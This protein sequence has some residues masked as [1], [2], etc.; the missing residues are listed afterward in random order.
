MAEGT[1]RQLTI[2]ARLR[3]ME[4][5]ARILRAQPPERSPQALAALDRYVRIR[6]ED[7]RAVSLAEDTPL[8]GFHR[9]R[10]G[11]N[12]ETIQRHFGT[13]T[14]VLK[15]GKERKPE[16]RIQ[17]W[18][19]RSALLNGGDLRTPLGLTGSLYD[20]L[21]F[22][23]DEVSLG[24]AKHGGAIRCDLL[25]VGR[26]GEASFPVLIEL[27]SGREKT[28]LLRQLDKFCREIVEHREFF[29]RLLEACTGLPIS[30][31]HARKLILWPKPDRE[32]VH[33]RAHLRELVDGGIDVVEYD[34][35]SIHRMKVSGL[36]VRAHVS[37]G[38]GYAPRCTR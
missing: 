25:G 4:N 37:Y 21:L 10:G 5:L 27:K 3:Q 26:S 34:P 19:I 36:S 2:R 28:T 31:T 24:D 1:P 11:K 29:C 12:L 23:L 16:R 9:N 6:G 13:C 18:L 35:Q 33:T 7:F 20:E 14:P 38:A 32:D 17:C 30:E 22:A 8:C 15:V